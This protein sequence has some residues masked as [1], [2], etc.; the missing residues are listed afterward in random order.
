MKLRITLYFILLIIISSCKDD[1][2]P[3]P[4]AFLKLDYPTAEYQKVISDCPFTFEIS[5]ES[6]VEFKS[7]CS[8]NIKYP[9]LNAA[10]HLTYRRID[11]NLEQILQEVEKLTYEHTIKADAIPLADKFE[12][13]LKSVYGKIINVEG[14]VAS[15]IQ[16][17]A[18]DSLKNVL[19]GSLYFNVKP[20]YDSILPAINYIEKDIKNL[21]ESIEWN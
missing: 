2:L 19:H 17:N 18:T 15:N 14:D 3:K 6:I 9:R 10:I 8:V 7:D 11:D 21:M 13:K 20:N 1:V 4:N 12:N 5:Q 16:F